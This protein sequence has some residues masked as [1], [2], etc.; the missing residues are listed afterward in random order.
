MSV[1]EILA[2]VA[3]AA[4]SAPAK[5]PRI[6]KFI[7]TSLWGLFA[8]GAMFVGQLAAVALLVMWS[9][10]DASVATASALLTNGLA[11]SLSVVMGVPA[12]FAALW[13]ATRMTRMPLAG[14]LALRT[15]SWKNFLCGALALIILIGA[16]D[17]LSRA[18]GREVTPDFMIE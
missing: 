10:A 2:D 1:P 6:W 11:I 5:P 8:F 3:P 13:L 18:M 16:W 15:A 12:V 7:G 14:Y 17:G 4:V 9:R